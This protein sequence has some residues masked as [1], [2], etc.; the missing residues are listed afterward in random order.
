MPKKAVEEAIHGPQRGRHPVGENA[1]RRNK[2]I[3]QAKGRDDQGGV[4]QDVAEAPGRGPLEA[5]GRDRV[6]DLLDYDIGYLEI[7]AVGFKQ[8][9]IELGG[10]ILL[11]STSIGV[12][13]RGQWPIQKGGL[14]E[15]GDCQRDWLT[16]FA[17][18]LPSSSNTDV[19]YVLGMMKIWKFGAYQNHRAGHKSVMVRM[20][21]GLTLGY[22]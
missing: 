17:S 4:P 10:S 1:L 6:A 8:P 21:S 2:T 3:E 22:I 14:G 12:V 5:L 15:C 11:V 18:K 9:A 16:P 20:M 13:G 19:I 7:L